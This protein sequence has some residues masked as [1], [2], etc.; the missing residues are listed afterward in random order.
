MLT[1]NI[2]NF[3]F[4]RRLP[5]APHY[6]GCWVGWLTPWRPCKFHPCHPPL[7]RIP[8]FPPLTTAAAL[9]RRQ[10]GR[11]STKH[12]TVWISSLQTAIN[13]F[14]KLFLALKMTIYANVIISESSNKNHPTQHNMLSTILYYIIVW[15]L[16]GIWIRL[17]STNSRGW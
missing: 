3:P 1:L 17:L 14:I 16:S 6:G 10:R 13:H 8:P 11:Q 4:I 2:H 9:R 12:Q 5:R 15:I 7:P